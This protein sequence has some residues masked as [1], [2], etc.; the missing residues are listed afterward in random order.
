M[1]CESRRSDISFCISSS[2]TTHHQAR[3]M[4]T[5]PA[6]LLLGAVL[7]APSLPSL[8]AQRPRHAMR[9]FGSDAEL[10]QYLAVLDRARPS[11]QAQVN[12]TCPDTTRLAP[13]DKRVI[14]TGRISD[15]VGNAIANAQVRAVGRCTTAGA[16]GRNQLELPDGALRGRSR[17][18]VA[19]LFIGY[20]RAARD[21]TFRGR[22]AS[23][24]FKLTAAPVQLEEVSLVSGMASLRTGTNRSP[25]R[26]TP[27][28]T[29]AGSSSCTVTTWWCSGAALHRL[30]ARGRAPA[31]RDGGCL[32]ARFPDRTASNWHCPPVSALAWRDRGPSIQAAC[33]LRI[34]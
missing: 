18:R 32:L 21:V 15:T 2:K 16:D 30:G 26:S 11:R 29:R 17:V 9:P 33:A 28:W 24:D 31:G 34:G 3:P 4:R 6:L 27:A 23:A 7:F 12:R 22:A 8:H 10:L 14:I 1:W 13:G 25:T 19:A 20:R 5:K